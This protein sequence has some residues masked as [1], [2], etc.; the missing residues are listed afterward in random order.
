MKKSR[1]GNIDFSAVLSAEARA[2]RER[3]AKMPPLPVP[4]TARDCFV[5]GLLAYGLPPDRR[6]MSPA[7]QLDL[8]QRYPGLY[9]HAVDEPVGSCEPFAREGFACGD[10]WFGIIDRL[11]AKLA[12]DPNLRVE[13]LKEKM[14][15]LTVYF[16]QSAPA[17]PDVEA[18][19]DAALVDAR[20]ESRRTCEVCGEPGVHRARGHHV[21]S[22]CVPCEWLDEMEEACS[23]LAACAEA[24]DLAS[25]TADDGSRLDAGRRHLQHLGEAASHQSPE[26]RA[27]LPGVDWTRLDLL[28]PLEAVRGMGAADVWGFIRDEVPA[29]A[30]A[31]R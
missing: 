21:G 2:A 3:V 7:H 16:A 18:S 30:K 28:R 10:G 13:Q 5:R 27:R 9:H 17:S 1:R 4:P 31:L 14:G 25:F 22:L 29:L 6:T 8:V 12:A 20:E 15:L 19:T 24:V 23:R 11:S 26:R